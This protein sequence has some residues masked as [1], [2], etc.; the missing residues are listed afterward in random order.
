MTGSEPQRAHGDSPDQPAA[1]Q[2][3]TETVNTLF[4]LRSQRDGRR[5]TPRQWAKAIRG[6]TGK[7]VSHTWVERVMSGDIT[8]IS[9][10]YLG[11]LTRF[12]KVSPAV[13]FGQQA[14]EKADVHDVQWRLFAEMADSGVRTIA[15]LSDGVDDEVREAVRVILEN[16]QKAKQTGLDA[17]PESAPASSPQL[18]G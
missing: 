11:V 7:K 5:Y 17:T 16:A 8:N 1:G 4:E 2:T 3:L 10:E 9:W 18:E 13:F 15:M 6:E 12:F 14:S